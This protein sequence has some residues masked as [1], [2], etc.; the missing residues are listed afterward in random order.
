M[1]GVVTPPRASEQVLVLNV[2]LERAVGWGRCQGAQGCPEPLNQWVLEMA[3][4]IR[5]GLFLQPFHTHASSFVIV[6]PARGRSLAHLAPGS[7][8]C[9]AEASRALGNRGVALACSAGPKFCSSAVAVST[10]TEGEQRFPNGEGRSLSQV[11]GCGLGASL[12]GHAVPEER[13]YHGQAPAA[14]RAVAPS[15][16]G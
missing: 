10:G 5:Q 7:L 6:N 8:H 12:R 4:W 9:W 11:A 2:P 13:W 1:N 14:H 15:A 3:K 16:P